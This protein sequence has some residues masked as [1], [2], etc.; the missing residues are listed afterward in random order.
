MNLLKSE[1]RYCNPFPNAMA[2]NKGQQ[3]DFAKYDAKL[4]CHGK[5]H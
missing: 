1:V 2:T 5:V 3:A 4:G